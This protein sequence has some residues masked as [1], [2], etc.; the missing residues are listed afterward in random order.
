[1]RKEIDLTSSGTSAR[2]VTSQGTWQVLAERVGG[3]TLILAALFLLLILALNAD[4]FRKPIIEDGDFAANSLIVQQAKHLHLLVG[5]YSRWGFHHPG[6]AYWYLFALGE[7][8]FYDTLH[9]VPAPFNAQLVTVIIVNVALL[10]AAFAIFKRH[11]PQFSIPLAMAITVVITALVNGI[12]APSM[13]VSNW[14]PDLL[15]FSYLLFAVSGASVLGGETRDLPWMSLSGMLLIHAHLSQFMFVGLIGGGVIAFLLVPAARQGRLRAFVIE[16]R[17]HFALAAAL[18]LILALPPLLDIALHTPNNLDD[19]RAYLHAHAGE[20]NGLLTSFRYVLCFFLFVGKPEQVLNDPSGGLLHEVLSRPW[21]VI[22]WLLFF[23]S[24]LLTMVLV[25]IDAGRSRSAFPR[26]LLWITAATVILFFYWAIRITGLFYVFNGSFFF[27]V[28]LLGW[29]LLLAVFSRGWANKKGALTIASIGFTIAFAFINRGVLRSNALSDPDVFRVA[30]A[31]S[32]AGLGN[33]ELTFQH[34][35]WPLATGVANAI[36][37]LGKPFCVSG[38]WGYMFTRESVCPDELKTERVAIA[39]GGAPCTPPCRELYRSKTMS[40]T[41]S[42]VERL[43]IPVS[44]GLADTADIKTGFYA[45]EG[46]H[47]WAQKHAAI[48]FLLA[49]ELPPATCFQL[50]LTGFGYPGRPTQ[51]FLNGHRLGTVSKE[52]LDTAVF[53]V[54]R[55]NL[56]AGNINEVSLDTER[57]GPVGADWREIG[58]GFNNLAL[59]STPA[60]GSCDIGSGPE[61]ASPPVDWKAGCYGLEG[62][63]PKEWRWCG[64][65]SALVIRNPYPE[66]RRVTVRAELSTGHEEP[67]PVIIRSQ[68][69]SDRINVNAIPRAYVSTLVLFPGENTLDFSC[70]A[71]KAEAP[72]DPRTMV[73]RFEHFSVESDGKALPKEANRSQASPLLIPGAGFYGLEVAGADTWRW[74]QRKCELILD[75]DTARPIVALFAATLITGQKE[76]SVVKLESRVFTKTYSVNADGLNATE[77]F[78]LP[79]GRYTLVFSTDAPRVSAP[80]DPRLLVLQVKNLR[81]GIA[82]AQ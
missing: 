50:R 57:A 59:R 53:P 29:F 15:L 21:I 11:C 3:S 40:A 66:P 20:R 41:L 12:A 17:R 69:S 35:D 19:V 37:R 70:R 44:I 2:S 32:G 13:L 9:L 42:S 72:N 23:A 18:C 54:A 7:F 80:G 38:D 82:D 79:P 78:V 71:P 68:A 60:A 34:H 36:K 62:K 47:R 48:R 16:R 28:H 67:S 43:K 5:H 75:N 8:L 31:V 26:H 63:P 24:S 51:V 39:T 56:K 33:P 4:V 1:M 81:V 74:C 45:S 58:Y 64:S 25:R 30:I 55:D 49:P 52:T 14:P 22:Y 73:L 77:R 76:I 46:T 61:Y 6:P 27:V 10:F 65:E